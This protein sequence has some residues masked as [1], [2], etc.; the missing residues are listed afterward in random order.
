MNERK[1]ENL[2][3]KKCEQCRHCCPTDLYIGRRQLRACV[4]LLDT[5]ERRPC[6][7]GEKCTVFSPK[8]EGKTVSGA[9]F[10]SKMPQNGL[11]TA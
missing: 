5:G 3:S 7:A 8:I 2:C 6:P 4:Y 9:I 11:A 10:C 1:A